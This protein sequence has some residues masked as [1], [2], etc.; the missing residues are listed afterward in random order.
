M[1]EGRSETIAGDSGSYVSS[2]QAW[3]MAGSGGS[4]GG[5]G[6]CSIIRSTQSGC[7][8]NLYFLMTLNI[9]S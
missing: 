1:A 4:G 7:S 5:S 8:E 2:G 6:G 3:G 9:C